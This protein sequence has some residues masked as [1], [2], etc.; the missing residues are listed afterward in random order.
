MTISVETII[1][2]ARDRHRSFDP[3]QHPDR[4]LLRSLS[5]YQRE[6]VGKALQ[7][8]EGLWTDE[9]TITLPLASFAAGEA[10]TTPFAIEGLSYVI[11]DVAREMVLVPLA[12]KDDPK[13]RW[14]GW[15]KN[16]RLFLRGVETDWSSVDSIVVTYSGTVAP[17]T[18]VTDLIE[19]PDEAQLPMSLY[20]C[21]VMANRGSEAQSVEGPGAGSF[22][23]EWQMCEEQFLKNLN[24]LDRAE[25]FFWREET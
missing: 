1:E 14:S 7:R 5:A 18:A 4:S 23:G 3:R 20:L 10:L 21:H 25:S 22:D 15:V 8:Y 19:L 12:H 16:R 11:N 13:P 2:N 24:L 6:L 17:L 9:Q